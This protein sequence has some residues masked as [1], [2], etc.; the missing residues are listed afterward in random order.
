M[1]IYLFLGLC[2]LCFVAG[3]FGFSLLYRTLLRW[4]PHFS[5]PILNT[6]ANLCCSL[7]VGI[8]L[9]FALIFF[10][11]L[12]VSFPTTSTN[13][14]EANTINIAGM[15]SFV[16]IVVTV[17][18]VA[19]IWN[20]VL[21]TEIDTLSSKKHLNAWLLCGSVCVGWNTLLIMSS[22]NTSSVF[23]NVFTAI[24]LIGPNAI[25]FYRWKRMLYR[26]PLTL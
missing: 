11:F 6:F 19:K 18:S 3:W 23:V 14:E 17:V 2:S 25:A 7:G 9:M 4:H 10:I 5:H 1:A 20:R 12:C 8:G 16:W 24:F 22:G 13:F 15:F 21:V 26:R